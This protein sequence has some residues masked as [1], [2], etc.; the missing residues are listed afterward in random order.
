MKQYTQTQKM[1]RTAMLAAI[2]LILA[3]TP[4]GYIPINPLITVT[5]MVTPVVLGGLLYGWP[6]G[7]FLGLV[8]GVSSFARAPG[9]AIGQ[10]ML[11]Q[12]GLLTFLACV[13]PRAAVG[14]FGGGAH[15]LLRR[16]KGL[17]RV[18]FYAATGLLGSMLNTLGFLLFVSFAFDQAKT[19]ITGGVIWGVVSFNGSIEAV[20]NAVLVA[21]LAGAVLRVGT[22]GGAGGE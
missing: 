17:R 6:A 1:A 10:M 2:T 8:F 15:F 3:L 7:L 18:W 14:L 21:L 20:V 11:S 22:R 5:I 4:L 13:V 12:S 19:G 9:E 16:K